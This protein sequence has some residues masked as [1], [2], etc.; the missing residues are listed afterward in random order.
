MIYLF[1]AASDFAPGMSELFPRANL[2]RM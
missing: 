1:L 2:V